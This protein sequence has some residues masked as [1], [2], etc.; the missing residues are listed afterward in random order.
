MDAEPI[1]LRLRRRRLP[2]FF[3]R[4]VGLAWE[5]S[6]AGVD[7]WGGPSLGELTE[8]CTLLISLGR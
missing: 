3:S 8:V 1:Y 2:F 5:V 7:I 4:L 6:G